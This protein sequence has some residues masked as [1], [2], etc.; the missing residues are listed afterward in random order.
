MRGSSTLPYTGSPFFS[1]S[2]LV[3]PAGMVSPSL[4]LMYCV[5]EPLLCAGARCARKRGGHGRERAV[6]NKTRLTRPEQKGDVAQQHTAQREGG[7]KSPLPRRWLGR[8]GHGKQEKSIKLPSPPSSLAGAEMHAHAKHRHGHSPP[9]KI[10]RMQAAEETARQLHKKRQL[11]SRATY[12]FLR[13]EDAEL[14]PFDR[15]QPTLRMSEI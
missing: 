8:T 5:T 14:H 15:A 4:S 6:D 7:K 2:N 11:A 3:I 13:G 12:N 9:R 1:L 10:G